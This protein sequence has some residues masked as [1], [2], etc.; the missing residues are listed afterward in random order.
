M[1]DKPQLFSL[2][3]NII[4]SIKDLGGIKMS[5]KMVI[6]MITAPV[7]TAWKRCKARGED[8]ITEKDVFKKICAAYSVSLPKIRAVSPGIVYEVRT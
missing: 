5:A 4:T 6:F 1:I 8:L 3:I 7:E 2:S